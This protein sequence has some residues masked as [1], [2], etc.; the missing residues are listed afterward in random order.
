MTNTRNGVLYTGVTSDLTSRVWQHKV[1]LYKGFTHKYHCSLLVWYEYH[2]DIHNA[3]YREKTIKRWRREWKVKLI[4]E[5]NPQWND[6]YD[7]VLE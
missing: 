4:E 3:I 1:H 2:E 6:L 5:M 7:S